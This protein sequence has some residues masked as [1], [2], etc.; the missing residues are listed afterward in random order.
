[1]I[2]CNTLRSREESPSSPL[3]CQP[4]LPKGARFTDEVDDLNDDD[5]DIAPARNGSSRETRGSGISIQKSIN[6]D[7]VKYVINGK[8]NGQHPMGEV[9]CCF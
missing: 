4:P 3:L 1:M 6:R 9:T 5:A 7:W 8:K 2:V